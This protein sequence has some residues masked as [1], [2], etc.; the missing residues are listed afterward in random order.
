MSARA[1]FFDARLASALAAG[2]AQQ[3]VVLAAGYD[4][5]AYRFKGGFLAAKFFEVDL[6][7]VSE[8]KRAL[9]AAT[10]PPGAAAG[11]A[12]VSADLSSP[13]QLRGALLPEGFD[14]SKPTVWLAQGLMMYLPAAAIAA[15][16]RELRALSAPGS[17]L[18]FDAP[19]AAAVSS[20]G[21][22]QGARLGFEVTKAATDLV[23]ETVFS[24]VDLSPQGADALA[25]AF[26][27]RCVDLVGYGAEGGRSFGRL[28]R[29]VEW[30]VDA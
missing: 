18:V 5:S 23:G 4:S 17:R 26:G 25:A 3:V 28:T 15:L 19:D 8:A 1:R 21:G 9:V 11:A 30:A 27:Y 29:C 16:L 13:R 12:F 2:A 6:P 22:L 14:P 7:R 20:G 10:L 24:S